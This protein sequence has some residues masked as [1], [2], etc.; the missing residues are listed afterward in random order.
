KYGY[1]L[2]LDRGHQIFQ[3]ARKAEVK[4]NGF[5]H[6]DSGQAPSI[7]TNQ[8]WTHFE[9]T[10]LLLIWSSTL[11]KTDVYIE[12][13]DIYFRLM[14]LLPFIEDYEERPLMK[15]FSGAPN[16]ESYVLPCSFFGMDDDKY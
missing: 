4:R 12:Q 13:Y 16:F 6:Y 10:L 1:G 3:R 14:N 9:S 2:D 7:T 8:L 5:I 11:A 15:G